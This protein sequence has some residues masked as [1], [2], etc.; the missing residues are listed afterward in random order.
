[1]VSDVRLLKMTATTVVDDHMHVHRSG[2]F[3]S[4]QW[5]GTQRRW[6][7]LAIWWALSCARVVR[8]A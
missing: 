6:G 4:V 5:V 3:G 7:V 1:M 2:S 8:P